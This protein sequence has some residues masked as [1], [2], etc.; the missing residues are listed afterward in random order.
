M[1]IVLYAPALA[2][3]QGNICC[4]QYFSWLS[5]SITETPN[6]RDSQR[7]TWLVEIDGIAIANYPMICNYHITPVCCLSTRDSYHPWNKMY[8]WQNCR[9]VRPISKFL[10]LFDNL[11]GKIDQPRDDFSIWL[12]KPSFLS[13]AVTWR[14]GL[15]AMLDLTHY[16]NLVIGTITH[17][18]TQDHEKAHFM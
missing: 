1:A 8:L 12:G 10:L 18:K 3:N 15:S 11:P 6:S 17:Y 9:F 13:H 7:N 2:L 16:D 4:I 5:L 14:H